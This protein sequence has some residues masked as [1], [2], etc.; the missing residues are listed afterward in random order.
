MCILH[1]TPADIAAALSG[2]RVKV[3]ARMGLEG[4]HRYYEIEE[5]R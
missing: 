5:R 3:L 1:E 2:Q 4:E